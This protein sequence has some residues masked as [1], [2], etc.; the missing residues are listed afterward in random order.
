MMEQNPDKVFISYS[1]HDVEWLNKLQ[2]MLKPLVR[3]NTIILWDDTNIKTGGEWKT[4]ILEALATAK[5]AV[6]LVS[7]N[8]LASD[9][10][11]EH[12][13]PRILEASAKKGLKIIWIAISHSLYKET[14]IAK[15]QAANDPTKPLDFLTP[16]EQNRV[17]VNI[18][19]QIKHAVSPQPNYSP[20]EKTLEHKSS[21]KDDK[22]D[23]AA[24]IENMIG[25][26]HEVGDAT[27]VIFMDVDGLS[28]I[29]KRFGADVGDEVLKVV[30]T[31]F[32]TIPRSH[33]IDS[34]TAQ[35]GEEE[36]VSCINFT[37]QETID[38]SEAI[39]TQ[40]ENYSW[41]DIAV[42]LHVTA[43]FGVAQ[44]SPNE[45]TIDC[46]LRA[47]H[48][49]FLAKKTGGNKIKK[50]PK[51]LPRHVSRNVDNYGS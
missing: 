29:N 48:G 7:P 42:D 19:N 15:Y 30:E 13:L 38:L 6:L 50:G 36:F 43:S 40:I 5:V 33:H 8:F 32:S 21:D 28:H 24:S 44:F 51:V 16:S 46:L 4:E 12:E 25:D 18:C 3:T 31:I 1:H 45:R 37:E 11:T 27:S 2:T 17:L 49:T 22:R 35:W 41:S 10:I 47:I 26:H 14:E 23:I 20:I 9:F 34:Y 39:R